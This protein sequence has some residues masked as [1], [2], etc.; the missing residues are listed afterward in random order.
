M[1][2]LCSKIDEICA[3]VKY[4]HEFRNASLLLLTETWLKDHHGD[5]H[6]A[7]DGFKLM[8]GDRTIDSGKERG[9]GVCVYV[10]KKWCHPDNATIK[11]Y[12]CS[13]YIEVLTV[14][15]RPYYLPREFSHVIV[16]YT[17]LIVHSQQL[18][19]WRFLRLFM[20]FNQVPQMYSLL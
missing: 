11:R 15:L 4:F 1:Q 16:L 20:N 5:A 3:N 13:T 10:N 14:S 19:S 17:Y 18:L 2:S 7:I 9:G 6:V 8:R 12:S